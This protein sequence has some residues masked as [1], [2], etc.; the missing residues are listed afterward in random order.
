MTAI[1]GSGELRATASGLHA[2]DSFYLFSQRHGGAEE[3]SPL[4]GIFN[5]FL[6]LIPL[7]VSVAL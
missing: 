1:A 4:G 7:R 2:M 5:A 3:R 6:L